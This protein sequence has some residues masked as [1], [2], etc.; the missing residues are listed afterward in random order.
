[1]ATAET[2][3]RPPKAPPPRKAASMAECQRLEQLPNIG[4]SLAADLRD[5]DLHHP[6]QLQGQDPL[7]LYRD[8]CVLRGVRQDPCVLDTFMA[9]VDFAQGGSPRAWWT[10]TA[11]RKA[12]YGAV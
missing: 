5:L 2:S 11:E 6:S 7:K 3:L 10:F 1:M 4:P 8:L 12:R 9:A